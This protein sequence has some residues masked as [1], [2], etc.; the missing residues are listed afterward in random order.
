M[1]LKIVI[2]IL[3]LLSVGT[4]VLLMAPE[5][6]SDQSKPTASITT[7]NI[8][9]PTSESEPAPEAPSSTALYVEEN[10][11]VTNEQQP[12]SSVIVSRA[13]L[14]RP[15]YVVVHASENGRAG[16]ILG[17]SGLR[18]VGEH[19]N[20]LVPLVR[21]SRDGELLIVMIHAEQNR[22]TSFDSS[23]DTAVQSKLGGPIMSTIEIR[24][25]A[26]REV[27]ITI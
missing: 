13:L 24:S 8:V 17:S 1:N 2:P 20:V 21:Q 5:T 27:P 7:T 14:S 25:S 11:L 9:P 22:N 4:A 26:S 16:A 18:A 12:G 15:G 6:S 3:V 10:A 23:A 19:G